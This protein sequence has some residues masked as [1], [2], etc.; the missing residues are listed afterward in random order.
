MEKGYDAES[1]SVFAIAAE[2]PHSV[3][4]HLCNDPE[5]ILDTM[6]SAMSNIASNTICTKWSLYCGTWA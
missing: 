3:T 2:A 5:G 6:C 4:D 1:N